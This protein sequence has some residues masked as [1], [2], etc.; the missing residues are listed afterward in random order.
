MEKRLGKIESVT[1]G[2]GGYQD[3][4]IGINVTL[5]G[6]GWGVC[7][8]KSEWDAEIVKCDKFCKWT[9]AGR[10]KNYAEIIRFLSKLLKDA[11]VSS[12]E[13]LKGTPV[14]VTF[15]GNILKDWRVLTEVV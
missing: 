12:V 13:K 2:H 7:D 15:D 4:M 8:S 14:E 6:S 5:S 9:E 10:D 1:F 3:V 11:K